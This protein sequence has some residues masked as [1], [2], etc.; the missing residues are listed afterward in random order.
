MRDDNNGNTTQQK[1]KSSQSPPLALVI[2][3]MKT[4][5]GKAYV[6]LNLYTSKDTYHTKLPLNFGD[7]ICS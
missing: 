3:L 2:G 5:F 4:L 7:C 6:W 1:A